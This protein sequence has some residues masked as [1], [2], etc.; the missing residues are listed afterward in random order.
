L[1]TVTLSSNILT[2]KIAMLSHNL[3]VAVQL[4]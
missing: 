2:F 3:W 4:K 1:G